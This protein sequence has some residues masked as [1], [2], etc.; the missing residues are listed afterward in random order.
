M[1]LDEFLDSTFYYYYGLVEQWLLAHGTK[2]KEKIQS[3]EE[4]KVLTFDELPEG[5]W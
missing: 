4:R 2:R 1:S 5:F 3:K